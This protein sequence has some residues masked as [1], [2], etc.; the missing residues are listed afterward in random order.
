MGWRLAIIIL[1]LAMGGATSAGADAP[2][3]EYPVKAAFLY[4]FG[5]FVEWPGGAPRGS[6]G[7][8][9][10]CVVGRDPFGPML[11]R[12]VRGQTIGGRA[13]AIRRM[14]AIAPASGCH[15]VYLGGSAD[16]PVAAA[17]RATVNEPVL[18]VA[19]AAAPGVVV[20]FVVR[21]NRVRFRIDT[22]AANA[23]GLRVSS[24]LLQ[25]AVEVA[26]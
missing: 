21:A 9:Q 19:E 13:I 5:S 15:I 2:S 22:R 4:Q 17:A 16:Q 23:R 6:D 11:E 7:L 24:K 25:L 18:T 12:V 26:R 20:Q 3:L 8:V 14:S 1:G 10:I